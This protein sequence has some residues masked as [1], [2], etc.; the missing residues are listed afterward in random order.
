MRRAPMHVGPWQFLW[1][2]VGLGLWILI[3]TGLGIL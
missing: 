1:M 2:A 3:L